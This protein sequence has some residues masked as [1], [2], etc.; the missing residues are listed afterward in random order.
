MELRR[1]IP[2]ILVDIG[3]AESGAVLVESML[4]GDSSLR[5]R[6]LSALNK[7]SQAHPGAKLDNQLIET[8]LAAEVMGHYR[9]YQAIGVLGGQLDTGDP[10]LQA[11]EESSNQEVERIFRL[12][13]VLFPKHD[14]HAAYLGLQST[15]TRVHDNALEF[16]DNTLRPELRE[17]L[18][19][20]VDNGIGKEERIRRANQLLNTTVDTSE[21][22][23]TML[24]KSGDPWLRSCAAYAVGA[25]GLKSLATELDA[26][27]DDP[28]PLLSETVRQAKLRLAGTDSRPDS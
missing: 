1:Q 27:Q 3:T 9:S 23:V 4:Q 20:L 11:L 26:W 14:L 12:L 5:F 2:S 8:V 21:E 28:D 24:L 25:L 15:N 19:P 22:A 18:V 7:F 16:L 17:L 6:I 10:S 13:G